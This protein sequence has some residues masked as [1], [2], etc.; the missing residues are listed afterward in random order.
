MV[1]FDHF[2]RGTQAEEE[3]V[4]AG[5]A[6]AFPNAGQQYGDGQQEQQQ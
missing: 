5:Q 6:G 4:L 2:H 3:L 1:A